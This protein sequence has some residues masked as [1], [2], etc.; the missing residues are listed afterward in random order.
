MT[1]PERGRHEIWIESPALDAS[2]DALFG[3]AVASLEEA[4]RV[5]PAAWHMWSSLDAF[6]QAATKEPLNKS[7][8]VIPA[9]AGIHVL[10]GKMV[11]RFRGDDT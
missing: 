5:H 8:L 9:K 1:D 10:Q 7:Q 4:V 11:P 3:R 2:E 6:N